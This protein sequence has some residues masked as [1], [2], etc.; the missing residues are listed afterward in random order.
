[1][2]LMAGRDLIMRA[3]P[4]FSLPAFERIAPPPPPDLVGAHIEAASSPGDVILDLNGRGGWVAR[5]AIDHQRRAVTLESNPLTRLLA[6]IV[7]R[8]PDIRHLDAAFG[9]IAA[10]PRQQSSLKVSIGELFGAR[11]PR[12]GRSVVVDEYIWEGPVEA[13]PDAA[14][15]MLRK[16][17]RCLACRDQ[18]GGGGQRHALAD[19]SD[20]ARGDDVEAHGPAWRAVRDRFPALDGDDTLADQLLGLHSPRQ[21]VGLHAILE[22]IDT[23]LRAAPVEA[24]LRLSLLQALLPASRLNGFPGRIASVRIVGGRLP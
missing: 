23:D 2:P 4:G 15:R 5:S 24:A 1:M 6:E 20:R 16:H 10:A 11:C 3:E 17:Y 21:L 22:R 9:A 13:E 7:L 18:V 19:D 8:P 14:P 12:C